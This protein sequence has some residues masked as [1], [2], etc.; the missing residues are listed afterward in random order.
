[1]NAVED[2]HKVDDETL[3]VTE[4]D[5]RDLLRWVRAVNVV[6]SYHR[7]HAVTR[8]PKVRLFR[9]SCVT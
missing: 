6:T 1:M 4:T 2:V 8:R 7:I 9:C 5:F 3:R